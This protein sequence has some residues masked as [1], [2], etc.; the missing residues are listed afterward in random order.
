MKSIVQEASSI[1][2]AIERGLEKAENPRD[3]SIKILEYPEKNFF[4]L[5]TKPA[6]IALYF[7]DKARKPHEAHAM[8]AVEKEEAPRPRTREKNNADHGDYDGRAKN[9]NYRKPLPSRKPEQQ[10]KP[11]VTRPLHTTSRRIEEPVVNSESFDSGVV[12]LPHDISRSKSSELINETSPVKQRREESV[13]RWNPEIVQYAREWLTRVLTEMHHL[14]PFGLE[15]DRFH[16]KITLERP[17]F[18][19]PE[20]ERRVLASLSLLMLETCKHMFKVN[21]RD[22]RVVLTHRNQG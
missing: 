7:D 20:H 2:K 1:A 17:L 14:V 19:D 8:V 11:F 15:V 5:T 13:V 16:I 12:A 6:K 10:N 21:L 18:D 4:G 9:N 22:H 3:F